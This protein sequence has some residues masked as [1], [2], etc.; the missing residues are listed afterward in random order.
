MMNRLILD[1]RYIIIIMLS[2]NEIIF[3]IIS[4]CFVIYGL[5]TIISC[6]W[7]INPYN[8]IKIRISLTVYLIG[9]GILILFTLIEKGIFKY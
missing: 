6:A 8:F 9:I 1:L 2:K 7:N 3:K 5:I 4:W